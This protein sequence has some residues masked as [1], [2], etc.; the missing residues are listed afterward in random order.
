MSKT[1][2]VVTIDPFKKEIMTDLFSADVYDPCKN[3]MQVD[4]LERAPLWLWNRQTW[5]DHHL[6]CDEEAS[7]K[8]PLPAAFLPFGSPQIILG[9]AVLTGLDSHDGETSLP[10]TL[11]LDVVRKYVRFA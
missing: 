1:I 6:W 8:D 10:C 3:F 9:R 2:R 7:F 11:D 4:M 5:G